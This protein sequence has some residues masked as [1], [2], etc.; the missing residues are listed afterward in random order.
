[1]YLSLSGG[2]PMRTIPF[3]ATA[4]RSAGSSLT[5]PVSFGS[6]PDR[7]PD[8]VADGYGNLPE[9]NGNGI[10]RIPGGDDLSGTTEV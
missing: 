2:E 1:M 6:M 4:L 7:L 3:P 5:R 8:L 9:G 10:G